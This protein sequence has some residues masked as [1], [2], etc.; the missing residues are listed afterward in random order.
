MLS[1]P[2][3]TYCGTVFDQLV[4]VAMRDAAKRDVV[5]SFLAHI[6]WASRSHLTGTNSIAI[7]QPFAE[8]LKS[9]YTIMLPIKQV[10][11]DVVIKQHPIQVFICNKV[12]FQKTE[13]GN[14]RSVG[15]REILHNIQS[16]QL[17]N[18]YTKD[19]H[20]NLVEDDHFLLSR[21]TALQWYADSIQ[22]NQLQGIVRVHICLPY[23][24][25][26][27]KTG[28]AVF[29]PGT[30]RLQTKNIT[31]KD[32]RLLHINE[33]IIDVD[34][35]C[36]ALLGIF[37]DKDLAALEAVF[38]LK[39]EASKLTEWTVESLASTSTVLLKRKADEISTMDTSSPSSDSD[40]FQIEKTGFCDS[41]GILQNNTRPKV[42][43][44]ENGCTLICGYYCEDCIRI[45]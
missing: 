36:L 13:S 8:T 2:E 27:S 40:E 3:K 43:F 28:S 23:A 11:M 33:A 29:K 20:G 17:E 41:C 4:A 10:G 6:P 37:Q 42:T 35:S 30:I 45:L 18:I 12:T 21:N 1:R 22:S 38:P 15:K 44:A 14:R 7:L 19:D 25:K 39:K 16:S 31:F 34:S 26:P 9:G 5:P 24:A 32:N